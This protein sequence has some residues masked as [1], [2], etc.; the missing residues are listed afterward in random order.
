MKRE[1][2]TGRTIVAR[3]PHG[4]DLLESITALCREHKLAMGTVTAIGALSDAVVGYYDQNQKS[5]HELPFPGHSEIL[6]LVGTLSQRDGA[7]MCHAHV[8]LADEFGRAFGGHLVAG[9]RIFAAEVTVT[10]LVGEPLTR[11]FD[12]V[13]GLHLWVG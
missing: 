9:C 1:F 8:T 7:V 10:E 3:L 4:A 13:T 11:G 6:A 2:T 12:E 5:Y